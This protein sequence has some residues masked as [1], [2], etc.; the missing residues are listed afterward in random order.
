MLRMISSTL[1]K[2]AP[3]ESSIECNVCRPSRGRMTSASPF[4]PP[5]TMAAGTTHT[6]SRT[7]RINHTITHVASATAVPIGGIRSAAG[8]VRPNSTTSSA[9]GHGSP[10]RQQLEEVAFVVARFHTVSALRVQVVVAVPLLAGF[11]HV[12]C[13][14]V[15]VLCA[16]YQHGNQ[17][18]LSVQI[19]ERH[20]FQARILVTRKRVRRLEARH[21]HV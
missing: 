21:D 2:C 6:V 12:A 4:H 13:G 14:R 19:L 1:S 20:N 9:A 10:S 11:T 8:H 17:H 15:D 7:S 5:P 16:A 3:D 18:V